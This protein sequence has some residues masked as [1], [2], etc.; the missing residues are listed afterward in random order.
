MKQVNHQNTTH[1]VAHESS[2]AISAELEV[3][4]KE[5]KVSRLWQSDATLWANS[6]ATKWMGWLNVTSE[7]SELPRIEA[8]TNEIKSSGI[9]DIVLLGM[10]GSSLC[11]AM[12]AKTFGA[13]AGYPQI[14]ILDS[15][16]PLQIR[17]L[18]E[19]IDLKST[20]FKTV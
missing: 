19:R 4:Q 7:H 16:D 14:H 18:E 11:P 17:H 12:M 9:T 13:I 5:N 2:A 10:G 1:F 6:D 8:L 20:F 15:T 3:W